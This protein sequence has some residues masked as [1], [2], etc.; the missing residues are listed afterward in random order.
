MRKR[1]R[2]S[3]RKKSERRD[4]TLAKY[5]LFVP[6]RPEWK[7]IVPIFTLSTTKRPK[8]RSN[9]KKGNATEKREGQR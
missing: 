5:L 3:E 7:R 4:A 8:L 6:N 1:K 9:R 2:Q